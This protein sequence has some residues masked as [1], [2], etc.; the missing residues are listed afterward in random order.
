MSLLG[1][2]QKVE[3]VTADI[4]LNIETTIASV[5]AAENAVNTIT[6]PAAGRRVGKEIYVFNQ[7][8]FAQKVAG[9][10]GDS[11]FGQSLVLPN[12]F[13]RYDSDGSDWYCLNPP[14]MQA[15]IN[16]SLSAANIIAMNA[17]P[18]SLIPAQGAGRVVLVQS[19]TI[20]IVRTATAF[21][22]GGAVEVRYTNGSGAKAG[23][24]ISSSFVTGAE[25]TAYVSIAGVV[26]ELKP[27]VNAAIVI[28][29]ATAG[30]AAG[31]GTAKVRLQC[32][33]ADFN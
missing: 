31:T 32:T 15:V 19:Y 3:S 5:P 20:Q 4:T 25:G 16:V 1:F 13:I 9:A 7:S 23:A 6:L 26:T 11:V 17:T 28:T 29:N 21:T 27:V 24:D 12:Q 14:G 33:F 22:G 18:I 30:F 10:S 8:L 2:Y